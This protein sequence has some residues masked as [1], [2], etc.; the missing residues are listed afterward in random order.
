MNELSWMIY[1]AE[2]SGGAKSALLVGGIVS[3]V[4]G[5]VTAA[6]MSDT[7][8]ETKE[9][10]KAT[11]ARR[12]KVLRLLWVP[13]AMISVG[14]F[15]PSGSTIYAIAAS[16]MGEDILNSETGSKAVKALDAWLDRQIEGE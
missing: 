2:V 9:D 15:L 16:E 11:L 7:S 13:M 1:A 4:I 6:V 8:F 5:A 14:I 10:A 12:D 3:L